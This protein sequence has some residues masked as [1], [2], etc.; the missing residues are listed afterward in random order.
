MATAI[1]PENP[2]YA[3]L[4]NFVRV[5]ER[6]NEIVE[7]SYNDSLKARRLIEEVN[8]MDTPAELLYLKDAV[9]TH[10]FWAKSTTCKTEMKIRNA[11][12]E[13]LSEYLPGAKVFDMKS[14]GKNI[15]DGFITIENEIYAV[16]V[17]RDKFDWSALVQLKRYMKIYNC[18][19]I[20]VA[21]KLCCDLPKSVTFVEVTHKPK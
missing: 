21:P 2:S 16:E 18:P 19:G 11:F 8:K 6:L 12:Y 5:A 1:L 20:A 9:L 13:N 15:P 3:N 10:L 7:E 17:K 4:A 14:D